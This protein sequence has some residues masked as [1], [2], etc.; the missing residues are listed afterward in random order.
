MRINEARQHEMFPKIQ[1]AHVRR[2][3]RY[4]SRI[5]IARFNGYD[6]SV[7]H[8]DC[9]LSSD[10]FARRCEKVARMDDVVIVL[11]PLGPHV[12][13]DN[14]SEENEQRTSYDPGA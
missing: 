3:V 8:H 2:H 6:L 1:D 7:Q 9:S 10:G 12:T 4:L 11:R 14:R 5:P 13:R